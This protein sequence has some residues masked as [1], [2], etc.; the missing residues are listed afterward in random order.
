MKFD[1]FISEYGTRTLHANG[2]KLMVSDNHWI[3][4]AGC[5]SELGQKVQWD[6]IRA[7]KNADDTLDRMIEIYACLV[8]GWSLEEKITPK[9][10]VSLIKEVPHLLPEIMS[11]YQ[12]RGNFTKP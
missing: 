5:D 11:F 10:A 6:M 8:I 3:L 9:K 4:I 12:D 7:D 1:E 2:A